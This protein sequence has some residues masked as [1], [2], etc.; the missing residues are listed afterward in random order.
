[1]FVEYILSVIEEN[2]L[3]DIDNLN[4]QKQ[5]FL[6]DGFGVETSDDTSIKKE[7]QEKEL[8][9]IVPVYNNGKYLIGRC[10]RSL[11]RSSIFDKMQIY[12]VDDGSTDTKTYDIID[13]LSK[14]ILM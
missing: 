9:V 4:I 5:M 12:L 13:E 3:E 14:D 11:L 10:F 6:L 8:A 2:K 7:D 1:M